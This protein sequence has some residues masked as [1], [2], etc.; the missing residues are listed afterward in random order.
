M[1]LKNNYY[2]MIDLGDD[3]V[4]NPVNGMGLSALSDAEI[5]G[6]SLHMD[7]APDWVKNQCFSTRVSKIPFD[8]YKTMEDYEDTLMDNVED[9]EVVL[10][11]GK[12]VTVHKSQGSSWPN[13]L[14]LDEYRGARSDYA[15]FLY[16]GL[17]RAEKSVTLCRMT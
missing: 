10:D 2:H 4:L 8:A 16:T 5:M 7:Y 12:S 3:L 15:K 14:V 11:F 13:V 1:C 17:T 6:S 9:D